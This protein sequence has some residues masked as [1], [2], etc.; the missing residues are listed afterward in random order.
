M[1]V[2]YSAPVEEAIAPINGENFRDIYVIYSTDG[3]NSWSE[4]QNLTKNT[5]QEDVFAYIAK[6]VDDYLHI[7]Y[8]EDEEP[9]TDVQNGD[10]PTINYLFYIKVPVADVLAD[11]IG[12]DP[13]VGVEENVSTGNV[14]G[15]VYP[16]PFSDQ[17]VLEV[18]L[19]NTPAMQIRIFDLMGKELF[20]QQVNNLTDGT[21][22]I[23][24]DGSNLTSG[25][26]ILKAQAGNNT[27]A[28]KLI[29]E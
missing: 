11:N 27:F 13:G 17:A 19:V 6:D 4:P 14:F 25:A 23:Q 10:P 21:N 3:G 1:Y 8:Q 18:K 28:T 2:V 7:V 29:V 20:S 9:G 5:T 15:N 24:I 22:Y 12:G 26:Y 16:N